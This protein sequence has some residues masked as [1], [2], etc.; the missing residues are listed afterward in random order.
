MN[1]FATEGQWLRCALHAHTTNSDGELPPWALAAHYRRA[2]FDV[3]ATT[4]HWARTEIEGDAAD[5]LVVIPSAELN[6]WLPDGADGHVLALGIDSIPDRRE[7]FP[8]LAEASRWIAEHG[9][10]SLLAHPR[11]T[12]ATVAALADAPDVLGIEVYNAGC[13]L[14]CSRGLASDLWDEVLQTGRRCTAIATDDSHLPGYDSALAWTMVRATE[15]TPAG[16]LDALRRGRSYGSC[17]PQIEQI[18][19]T[20]SEIHVRVSPSP[21]VALVSGPHD[22]GRVNAGRLGLCTRGTISETTTDGL[23]VAARFEHP[24]RSSWARLE[25]ADQQGRRA[26]SNSLDL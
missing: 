1:T 7:P 26:W 23:I 6:A 17:G 24:S 20:A 14:E 19:V 12:G 4:D 18:E 11:W 2:G 21:W 3:L 16:V 13:E 9:G 5:G 22:G 25:L 8:T 10:I 15:R